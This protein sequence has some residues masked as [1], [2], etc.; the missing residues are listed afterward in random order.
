MNYC[1]LLCHQ[2]GVD[3][4]KIVLEKMDISAKKYPIDKAKGRSTK[5]NK[6]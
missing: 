4:K 6:L 1:I 5:Y 3:P 2:I